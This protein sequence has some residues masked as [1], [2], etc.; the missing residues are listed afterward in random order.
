MSDTQFSWTPGTTATSGKI[1]TLSFWTRRAVASDGGIGSYSRLLTAGSNYYIRFENSDLLKGEMSSGGAA[2]K[3]NAVFQ[4]VSAWYHIVWQLDTT[5]A[6]SGDRVT[7]WVNGV[8]QTSLAESV[9]PSQDATTDFNASGT[10]Q[11]YG[12]DASA[13]Q[14]YNGYM[15]QICMV[16]GTA[17]AATTF[18]SFDAT[19]GEWKPKSD[20]EIRSAVTFGNN[21]YLLT[22]E[23]ASN[24]GYDYQTSDRSGTTNDFTKSGAGYQSK[25]NPSNVHGV[26]NSSFNWYVNSSYQNANTTIITPTTQYTWQTTTLGASK[27]KWYYEAYVRSAANTTEQVIGIACGASYLTTKQLGGE[28]DTYSYYGAGKIYAD[29]SVAVSSLPTYTT[30]AYIGC[31]FDLDNNKIYWHKDGTYINSGDPSAG[32]GGQTITAADSQTFRNATGFYFPALGD[33]DSAAGGTFDINL[34]NGVFGTT[35]L[36]GT[37]Y[38]DSD[39]QGVFKYTV[40]TGYKCLNTKQLNSYG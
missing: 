22:F 19:T 24:P 15:A 1:F 26:F 4:D 2:T 27:G 29:G 23:N 20:G 11:Y 31:A 10:T 21:G 36:G 12:A 18:G 6:S 32:T 28:P 35:V 14:W 3:T 39:G 8:E 16:D 38:S 9:A 25:E 40:P 33:F 5:Q 34:G 37:T 30:G 17:Y 13:G 7:V